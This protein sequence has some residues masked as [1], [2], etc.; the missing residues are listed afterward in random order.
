MTFYGFNIKGSISLVDFFG[1][2]QPQTNK[3]QLQS[4][5]QILFFIF[6]NPLTIFLLRDHFQMLLTIR[7]W[8]LSIILIY[9]CRNVAKVEIFIICFIFMSY[10]VLFL[11]YISY[12]CY[13]FYYIFIIYLLYIICFFNFVIYLYFHII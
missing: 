6:E 2:I 4:S 7:S 11:L 13:M 5:S 12:L 8:K 10:E 1:L 3:L 9:G